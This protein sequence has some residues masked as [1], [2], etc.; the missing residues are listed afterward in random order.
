MNSKI[1]N[2]IYRAN[3]KRESN[4]LNKYLPLNRTS[5][6]A[7]GRIALREGLRC[8][9]LKKGETV[10]VPSF[11]CREVLSSFTE[12]G[13]NIVFYN[14]DENLECNYDEI[15]ALSAK[16]CKAILFVNYF[17]FPHPVRRLKAIAKKCGIL[18]FEDNAHGFLSCDKNV[19]LGLRGDVG[20]FSLRKTVNVPNGAAL[21][22]NNESL[23]NNP[24]NELYEKYKIVKSCRKPE[25]KHILKESV[26]PFM[27]FS[28]NTFRRVALNSCWSVKRALSSS[29]DNGDCE[30]H[31]PAGCF[32]QFSM[33][34]LK[35]I[36]LSYEIQKRR[37]LFFS[38]KSMI[39]N[40]KSCAPIFAN[41]PDGVAPYGYPFYYNGNDINSF[42]DSLWKEGVHSLNWPSLPMS[43]ENSHPKFYDKIVVIPFSW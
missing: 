40:I 33:N 35:K 9:E 12:L 42:Q 24:G 11:I 31:V 28:G 2:D 38:F 5:F 22:L 18:L 30:E 36:D 39:D 1:F 14:I 20:I 16:G 41:L 8:C 4:D 7:F 29:I 17:G 26:R 10:L 25:I 13:I 34:L 32:S 15:E 19:P 23:I 43:V 6:F 37:S 27:A 3:V 21:V